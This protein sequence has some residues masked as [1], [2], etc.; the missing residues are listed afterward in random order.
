MK[1][2]ILI[3]F[4][5]SMLFALSF[6]SCK[7]L[8]DLKPTNGVTVDVAYST[9][10]GY[11]E[12]FAKIY[13]AFALTGNQGGSGNPDISTN[14][15]DEGNSDFLR[16]FWNVQELSTDEAIDNSS[17]NSNTD[18]G[19]HDFHNMNWSSSN[20]MLE[21]LFI[22]SSYQILLC[23]EFIRQCSDANL[24]KRGITGSSA[25]TIRAY[26]PEAR[27]LRAFQYWVL[28]D[29]FGNPSF[30]T[31]KDAIGAT[32]PP[33]IK[34][35][36]L[37]NYIESELKDLETKL[38]AP[39]TNVYGR[40]DRAAAWALLARMYLNA[41]VYTGTARYNDAV[42]YSK[43]VIDAGYSLETNSN[44]LFLNDNY[45]C[46]N[47][48]IFTINYDGQKSQNYGGT[49]YI[50][51]AGASGDIP[52]SVV[53]VSGWGGNRVTKN[54]PN[55]FPDYTG[56]L[57]KRSQ[58]FTTNRKIDITDRTSDGFAAIK[59][60]NLNRDGSQGYTQGG[61]LGVGI[62][63]P[64][65]RLGEQYLIYAEAVLRGATNGDAAT[66]LNY[67]NALRTRA[68]GNTS[69]N[70]NSSQLTL[71]FILDERGRELYWE[72]FRR[73]DLIRFNKFTTSAYLW[74]WKG[75][76]ANGTGVESFRNLY[77]IPAPE[78]S[79]NANL[80]QNPGY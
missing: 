33:Q 30:S 74:P 5:A 15:I 59:F 9:P 65:F 35:A 40:A 73:T 41:Q 37:F 6:S 27:F 52:A 8:L 10:Q 13:G 32:L 21:G 64:L 55:L 44:W 34:R 75:N 62:D 77:P 72:C 12:G 17:W 63:M 76:I 20:R 14:V 2:N 19:L 67:I 29:C 47:E 69:G 42:T 66:A 43:K 80:I 26:I 78:V 24:S 71:N 25:D 54:L 57:D 61:N 58:F 51:Y 39:R 4:L 48:F 16:M 3:T 23:N 46:T 7:K 18:A 50:V 53:G 45:K 70:I 79:A 56:T 28:M 60:K 49:N 22:R 38:P 11:K 36:D 31:E 1:Q 68:Y